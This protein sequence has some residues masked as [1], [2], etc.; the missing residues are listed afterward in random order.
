[1]D[2]VSHTLLTEKV[3]PQKI[4]NVAQSESQG[5]NLVQSHGNIDS[6]YITEDEAN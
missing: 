6:L 2:P 4:G 1:M 3:K 5:L